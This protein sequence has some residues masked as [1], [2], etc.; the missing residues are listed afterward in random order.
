M[1]ENSKLGGQLVHI[2]QMATMYQNNNVSTNQTT[3]LSPSSLGTGVRRWL[4]TRYS[5]FLHYLQQ[6]SRELARVGINVTK[7]EIQ[8]MYQQWYIESSNTEVM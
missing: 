7:N 6:D 2:P 3:A 5:S 4:F 1:A 8:K